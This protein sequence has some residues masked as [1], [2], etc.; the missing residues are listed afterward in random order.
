MKTFSVIVICFLFSVF[1]FAQPNL[2]QEESPPVEEL[3]GSI[4]IISAPELMDVSTQWATE[5]E[6]KHPR[7]DI[8]VASTASVNQ[9]DILPRG[10][11][12]RIGYDGTGNLLDQDLVQLI[13]GREITVAIIHPENPL[14]NLLKKQGVT[15]QQLRM[16]VDSG[17]N[18]TWGS[19]AGNSLDTPINLVVEDDP[20]VKTSIALLMNKED[21][22]DLLVQDQQESIINTVSSNPYAIGFCKMS[23]I[24]DPSE[25]EFV[26][27]VVLLPIDKNSNGMIDPV[28]EIY[29]NYSAF[30]RG[31]WIGKYPPE[32]YRNIYSLSEKNQR[33]ESVVAFLQWVVTTGQQNLVALGFDDIVYNE[34]RANMNALFI[35]EIRSKPPR[36]TYAVQKFLAIAI[37]L[38]VVLG[39]LINFIVVILGARKAAVPSY[40]QASTPVF[41]MKLIKLRKGLFFNKSHMW[42]FMNENGHVKIGIDDFLQH[43]TGP[44]TRVRMKLPG[45]RVRKG[46]KILTVAQKGK[47]ISVYSPVSGIIQENNPAVEKSPELINNSPYTDGW[48]YLIE[49]SNWKMEI[50]EL[51]M[52]NNYVSW[53]KEEFLRFKDFLAT[54]LSSQSQPGLVL[55]EGGELK[56]G[57]L[58]ECG[59]EIWE[60]FQTNFIDKQE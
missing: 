44:L 38:F 2:N 18:M 53:L 31:V 4:H 40:V 36:N 34:K 15:K 60:E 20:A 33:K 10:T 1:G 9:D 13:L 37:G 45:E 22:D 47:R 24:L 16:L 48:V 43:A 39:L 49:P 28:E 12:I 26:N 59:P 54:S 29:D 46:E 30:T 57:I 6:S 27:E 21:P 41:D 11:N 58:T 56:D 55:Q 23:A 25:Q 52:G 8:H 50:Q 7:L 35:S 42:A 19:L 14:I 3:K 51:L 32:L 17:Q 5:F